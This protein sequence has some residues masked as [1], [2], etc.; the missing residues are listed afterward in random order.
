MTKVTFQCIRSGNFVS[1]NNLDDISGLRKHEGYREVVSV[2]VKQE[3][4]VQVIQKRGRPKAAVPSFLQ[5]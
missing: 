5:E 4:P 1:F 3:A 2:P